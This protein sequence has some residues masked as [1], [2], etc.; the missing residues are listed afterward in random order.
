MWATDVGAHEVRQDPWLH[1]TKY[2]Y[3]AVLNWT[4]H[5]RPVTTPRALISATPNDM[6]TSP[7]FPPFSEC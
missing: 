4:Q 1:Q 6:R 2:F 7:R 5:T 3:R